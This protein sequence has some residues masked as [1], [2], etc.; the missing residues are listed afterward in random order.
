MF[1]DMVGYS[2]LAQRDEPLAIHLLGVQRALVRP[3]FQSHGGREVN[4]MG[5]GFLVEFPSAL[6][7]LECAI[8]VQRTLLG[9]NER[10][11][12]DRVELRIGIHLGDVVDQAGDLLG[13]AVNIA[14]RIEPLAETSGICISGPVF[15]QVR[16]KVPYSCIQLEHAFLKNIDTP[17]SVYSVD[18]PWHGPSAARI[19]PWTDREAEVETLNG[20]LKEAAAGRGQVIALSGEP[21]IGKTRLAEETIR[22]GSAKGFRTL[23]GRGIQ[24]QVD[25]PYGPWAEAIRGFVR[26]APD[27]LLYKLC[28]K[29]QAAVVKLVPELV[30]RVGPGPSPAALEAEQAR[31]AFFEGVTQFVRNLSQE[32]PLLFLLDD[33]QWADAA[34]LRL[35]EYLAR[36]VPSLRLLLILSHRDSDV[37]ENDHLRAM[38]S[39]LRKEHLLQDVPVKRMSAEPSQ[40]LVSAILSGEAPLPGLVGIVH[41]RTGGNP[42]FAEELLRSMVEEQQLVRR[43]EGWTVQLTTDVGIPSSM[44]ELI[45]RRVGRVSEESRAVLSTASVLRG[46]I[47]FDLLLH[48]SG[49]EEE[50]LIRSVEELLRAR[51]LREREYEPGHPMY[52][53]ADDETHAVLYR[54]FSLARRQRLH[55]KVARLLEE[56]HAGNPDAIAAQLSEHFCRGNDRPKALQYSAIAGHQAAAVF[57]HEEAIRYYETALE[58]MNELQGS[59]RGRSREQNLERA[60][61]L[62]SLGHEAPFLAQFSSAASRLEEAARLYEELG[63]R[64][65]AGSNLLAAGTIRAWMLRSFEEGLALMLQARALVESEPESRLHADLCLHLG[66]VAAEMELPQLPSA[67][68]LLEQALSVARA[69]HA[70]DLEAKALVDLAWLEPPE[71]RETARRNLIAA[72]E[73]ARRQNLVDGPSVLWQYVWGMVWMDGDTFGGIGTINEGIRWCQRIRDRGSEMGFEGTQLPIVLLLTGEVDRAAA[74]ARAGAQFHQEVGIPNVLNSEVRAHLELMAGN[75]DQAAALLDSTRTLLRMG[76]D[77][78]QAVYESYLDGWLQ[79]ERGDPTGALAALESGIVRCDRRGYPAILATLWALPLARAVTVSL[80]LPDRAEAERRA[81]LFRERLDRIADRIPVPANR[82][83]ALRARAA[84]ETHRGQTQDAIRALEEAVTWWKQAGWPYELALTLYTLGVAYEQSKDSRSAGRAFDEALELFTQ[85]RAG[86][87]IERVRA[88]KARPPA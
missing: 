79:E 39:E 23:H 65:S 74:G 58:L 83:L 5:D 47:D 55:L 73:L 53:F 28:T 69:T 37:T 46:E 77:T 44:R 26:D 62:E 45:L 21:G 31:L 6:Q 86:R 56:K 84:W 51:L 78:A 67:R 41:E 35:I 7:A 68:A 43:P 22:R 57:A 13:D 49:M 8:D 34:S 9:H 61:L 59:G 30:D 52:R 29:C 33:I 82:G 1:T 15:D 40:R 81:S 20:A 66:A 87:D 19:T 64:I 38:L 14:A 12:S 3:V 80:S 24:D 18:L 4:R 10:S 27:P 36:Q 70:S 11:A 71:G 63:E 17:I 25:I 2:A 75:L 48:L 76:P 50:S 60:R 72:L 54:E 85:L 16:N 88:R 32:G 42:L